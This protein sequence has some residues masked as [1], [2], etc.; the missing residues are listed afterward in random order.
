MKVLVFIFC[1]LA[2]YTASAQLERGK[3]FAGL[4]AMVLGGD[5]YSTEF[6]AGSGSLES[7]YGI[8]LAPTYGYAIFRNWLLGAA[9]TLGYSRK[10]TPD[11]FGG[12]II[13]HN[14]DLGIGPFTRVYLDLSRNGRFKAFGVASVEFAM[15]KTRV[16]HPTS[17]LRSSHTSITAAVGGGLGYFGR[18]TAFDLNISGVG[19]RFGVYKTFGRQ[20]K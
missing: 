2:N 16:E 5:I 19:I 8:N 1:L 12:E 4:Q 17:V 18:K 20:K 9:V 15:V 3:H 7:H 6:S 13:H 10:K 14:Y 11:Y